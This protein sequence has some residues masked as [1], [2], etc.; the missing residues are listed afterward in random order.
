MLALYSYFGIGSGAQL[1]SSLFLLVQLPRRKTKPKNRFSLYFIAGNGVNERKYEAAS[2]LGWR[3]AHTSEAR[4][5]RS[6]QRGGY[7]INCD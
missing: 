3:D 6:R 5:R 4:A 1:K 7:S 2:P